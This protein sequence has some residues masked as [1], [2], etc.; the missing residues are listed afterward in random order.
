MILKEFFTLGTIVTLFDNTKPLMIY[1]RLQLQAGFEK[2]WDYVACL[3]P[4][5]NI[6]DQYNVFFNHEDVENVL[7]VG[8]QTEDDRSYQQLLIEKYWQLRQK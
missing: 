3:Y 7:F 6:S 5:G 4:E 8:Y 1:G 2:I